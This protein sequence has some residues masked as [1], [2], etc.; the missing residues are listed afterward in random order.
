MNKWFLRGNSRRFYRV[1]MPVH[2]FI[3]PSTPIKNL[4]IYA[5]GTDYFPVGVKALIEKQLQE[6]QYWVKKI[7]DQKELL[8][9][10]FDEIIDSI[11]F[12]GKGTEE[13]SKGI[14][15]K[16]SPAYW[17]S[18]SQMRHGFQKVN[19]LQKTSP[20]TFGYFKLIEEKYLTFL[21]AFAESIEKSTAHQ[22]VASPD[23]PF[24]FKIDEIL[25]TF[26][27]P[28]F[29]NVPLVQ[30]IIHLASL[31]NTYINAFRQMN[32]DNLLRAYPDQWP[33]IDANIS[34]SGI[35]VLFSKHFHEFE[36]VDVFLCFPENKK[37]L[38]FEGAVVNIIQINSEHK[39]RIAIN[40][41]FPDGKAQ[42]FLTF[43]IQEHELNMCL[44]M[45]I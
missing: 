25:E 30:A 32:D 2:A 37:V 17:M 8:T 16:K 22:F 28:K 9:I 1:N 33:K 43:K 31:L 45:E 23:L 20:K 19:A 11:Q 39:E 21:N 6:T 42:D 7:Q 27:N 4:E 18:I 29:S 12:L 40:F 44:G 5:T 35:A 36:K 3:T 34:A 13:I 15:P 38:Q 14:N 26:N 24:A 41:E 10:L